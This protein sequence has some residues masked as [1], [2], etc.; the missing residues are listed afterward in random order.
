MD[1][2]FIEDDDILEK[3]N[4]VWDKVCSDIKKEFDSK[5]L[6][7]KEFLKTQ[8][9]SHGDEATDFY[10]KKI[11]KVVSN[12]TCLALISLDSALKK[13]EDY[14]LQV[15]LKECI[16]IEKYVV[17]Q[18]NDNLSD[19]SSSDN[20]DKSDE[21]KIKAIW[22]MLFENVVFEGAIPKMLFF[23]NTQFITFSVFSIKDF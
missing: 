16:Y 13:D 9:K 2:L 21:Q 3:Y 5:P 22:L 1:V 11:P 4:T 6:H 12:H 15:F 14:Y 23:F 19:F 20:S 17:S 7:N 8:I 10:D 18:I